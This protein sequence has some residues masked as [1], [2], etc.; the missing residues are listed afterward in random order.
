M[1]DLVILDT[2]YFL[3]KVKPIRN[4]QFGLSF[5]PLLISTLY[6]VFNYAFLFEFDYSLLLSILF[7]S[8]AVFQLHLFFI[9]HVELIA[10]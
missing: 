2:F 9:L 7:S 6:T 10:I 5:S 4:L 3:C 8:S 1:Y